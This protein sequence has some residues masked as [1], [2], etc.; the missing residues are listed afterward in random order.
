MTYF[1]LISN[2]K[3]GED[4]TQGGFLL[5]ISEIEKVQDPSTRRCSRDG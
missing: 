1:N 3:Y 5:M 2:W 4:I